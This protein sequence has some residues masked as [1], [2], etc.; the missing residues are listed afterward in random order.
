M[1][2]VKIKTQIYIGDEVK[3][4]IAPDR[5]SSVMS[6][7]KMEKSLKEAVKFLAKNKK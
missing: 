6:N 3:V 1:P 4:K 7:E 2:K 5:S